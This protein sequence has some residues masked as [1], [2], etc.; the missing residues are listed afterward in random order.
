VND[1]D[2]PEKSWHC[3]ETALTNPKQYFRETEGHRKISGNVL[4][5]SAQP[6][7]LFAS[8]HCS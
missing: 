2:N 1:K 4:Q 5:L 7:L 8:S 6:I 3:K